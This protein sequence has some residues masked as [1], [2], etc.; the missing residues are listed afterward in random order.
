MPIKDQTGFELEVIS[1]KRVVSLVPSQTEFLVD[2]GLGDRLLGVT[3]FCI[4]PK[5]LIEDLG[6]IGGTK[7]KIPRNKSSYCERNFLFGCRISIR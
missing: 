5:N 6:H 1:S 2:I 3:K 4:H 7:K